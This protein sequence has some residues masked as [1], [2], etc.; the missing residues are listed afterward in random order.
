MKHTG[1]AAFLLLLGFAMPRDGIPN[2]E[3]KNLDDRT[4]RFSELKGER[5]TVIDFWATWCAPCI[6]SIP[7]LVKM[8]EAFA[9]EGVNFV[10]INVD[11]PRN[12]SKVKPFA[13]SLGVTYPVLLD[14]NSEVMAQLNVTAMPTL[15]V[16]DAENEIVLV[17]EGYR[18]GDETY[19][20][21]EIEHLLDGPAGEE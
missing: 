3:L 19:L 13:R 17:H 5:L 16:V 4:V 18:P 20:R 2:F 10:G 8:S 12:L 21:E 6:R 9:S 14:T 11:S 1:L 7:E 15:L